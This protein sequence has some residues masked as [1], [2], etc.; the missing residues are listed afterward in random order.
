VSR[1]GLV[2]DARIAVRACRRPWCGPPA[3][4]L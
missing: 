1:R 3:H 4:L 2:R